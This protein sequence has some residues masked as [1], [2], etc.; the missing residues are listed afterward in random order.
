MG[1]TN[2]AQSQVEI[3]VAILLV[4][5]LVII[6]IAFLSMP[7]TGNI[8]GL[9]ITMPVIGWIILGIVAIIVLI[10]IVASMFK[11]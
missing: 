1:L 9:L 8:A 3:L 7:I 4:V 2:K 10:V 11:K 5:A 6:A